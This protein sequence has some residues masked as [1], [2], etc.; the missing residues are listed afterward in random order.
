MTDR[1]VKI[2]E[3]MICVD[4]IARAFWLDE[5]DIVLVL[6]SGQEIVCEGEY[7]IYQMGPLMSR[8]LSF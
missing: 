5:C 2:G 7:C 3:N 8:S 4:Q 1:N 6:K